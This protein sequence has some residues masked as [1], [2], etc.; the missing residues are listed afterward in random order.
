MVFFINRSNRNSNSTGSYIS[1]LD[2]HV[3]S[4]NRYVN[5]VC[6]G[7]NFLQ[8]FS[9]YDKWKVFRGD[10]TNSADLLFTVKRTSIFQIKTSLGVFLARNTTEQVCDFKIKGNYFERSCAFYRGN[11]DIMIAQ[12]CTIMY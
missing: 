12:V 1:P 6:D 7:M 10:S 9:M 3:K 2:L 11:L 8:V 4:S 5:T